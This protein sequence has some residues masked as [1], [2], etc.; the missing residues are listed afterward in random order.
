MTP[1]TIFLLFA[2][3]FL[4]LFAGHLATSGWNSLSQKQN[5]VAL[6]LQEFDKKTEKESNSCFTLLLESNLGRTTIAD[7]EIRTGNKIVKHEKIDAGKSQTI[8]E[9]VPPTALS[10]GDNRIEIEIR[11]VTVF[12]HT[13]VAQTIES[14]QTELISEPR[15]TKVFIR[16]TDPA[17]KKFEPIKIFVNQKLDHKIFFSGSTF[18]SEEKISLEEGE[19][20]VKVVYGGAEKNFSIKKEPEFKMNFLLGF[21][22]IAVSLT[23]FFALVFPLRPILE[24]ISL[25]ILSFFASIILI[26]FILDT[27]G[28][29]SAFNFTVLFLLLIIFL[30]AIFGKNFSKSVNLQKNFSPQNFF[31]NVSPFALLFVLVIIF[32]S[33]FY[34][35]LTPSYYSMFT[36]F[37]EREAELIAQNQTVPLTDP[38]SFLGTKTFGYVSAYFFLNAGISWLAG[39][40][41]MQSFAAIALLSQTAFLCIALLFFRSLGLSDKN[42][43]LGTILLLLGVFVFSDFLF[44]IRH[45]VANSFLLLS[46]VFLKRKAPLKSGLLLA[47]ATFVQPPVFLM[48]IALSL[49][50]VEWKKEAKNFFKTIFTGAIGAL[51]LFSPTLI[52]NGLPTQAHPETWGY[53]WSIPVYGFALDFLSIFIFTGVFILPLLF[54][55]KIKID[56]FAKKTI[57]ILALFM[58]VQLFVSYRINVVNSIVLAILIAHLFPKKLLEPRFTEYTMT[59]L[60]SVVFIAMAMLSTTFYPLHPTGYHAFEFIKQNTSTN[61]NILNEP[62]LGHAFILVSQRKSSADL[63]VEYANEEMIDNSYRFLKEKDNSILEK[64]GIDFIVNRSIFLDEKPIGDNLYQEVI[65]FPEQDKIYANEIFFIHSVRKK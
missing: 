30:T 61:A 65:E 48:H 58:L 36:S 10:A 60:F 17:Q 54:L 23:V 31:K 40:S 59:V 5:L 42:S 6:E 34:H 29:L 50:V 38:F 15:G 52:R 32:S 55:K 33:M 7:Y 44:N 43:L 1:K 8:N 2:G 19:N 63:A 41:T 49:V 9:C 26:F 14:T 46:L 57:L 47:L 11:N 56:G 16:V 3:I 24:R 28:F 20:N 45:V 62:Y 37:Y 12:F 64:Y 39:I 21:V 4:L 35:F 18:E 13:I 53:L 27:T 51:V 22:L 25:S